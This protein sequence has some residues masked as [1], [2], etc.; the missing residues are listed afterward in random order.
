MAFNFFVG[1]LLVFTIGNY[2]FFLWDQQKYWLSLTKIRKTLYTL[3]VSA[4]AVGLL[5]RETHLSNWPFILTLTTIIIFMDLALL[6]TPSIMKLWK[7]EFEHNNDLQNIILTYE[8]VRKANYRRVETMSAMIQNAHNYFP[9]DYFPMLSRARDIERYLKEYTDLY[10]ISVQVSPLEV[11]PPEYNPGWETMSE[12]E[13]YEYE[14][15]QPVYEAI[16]RQLD[17][18]EATHNFEM[19]N[20][21]EEYADY[22]LQYEVVSLI[23]EESMIVPVINQKEHYLIVLKSERGEVLEIDALHIV[24]LTNLY[25]LYR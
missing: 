17:T 10:G 1:A 21:K 13:K 6:L 8:K 18:I 11:S 25:H 20:H 7:A 16:L 23:E 4:L 12:E 3:F 2:L 22:L 14:E 19:G 24:N 15:V 9:E 5:V